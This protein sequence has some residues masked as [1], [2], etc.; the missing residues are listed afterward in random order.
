MAQYNQIVILNVKKVKNL[1]AHQKVY[2]DIPVLHNGKALRV[3]NI[4]NLELI[5]KK[6]FQKRSDKALL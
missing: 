1:G 5:P 3:H 6:S 4:V 2:Q